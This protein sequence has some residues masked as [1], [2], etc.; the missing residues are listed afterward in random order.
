MEF[1]VLPEGN[2]PVRDDLQCSDASIPSDDSN[3]V[4]KVRKYMHP[5]PSDARKSCE[6]YYTAFVPQFV[7]LAITAG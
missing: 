5:M 1:Q 4:I 7:L 2:E 3:L 6:H